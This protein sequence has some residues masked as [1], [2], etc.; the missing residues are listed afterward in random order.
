MLDQAGQLALTS[1]TTVAK[2]S[3]PLVGSVGEE[4]SEQEITNVV[5]MASPMVSRALLITTVLSFPWPNGWRFS[6]EPSEQSERPERR[7]G[8]RVRWKRMLDRMLI[9]G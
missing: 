8:R 7:R 1:T 2:P 3:P 9:R 4:L 5:T 6:G